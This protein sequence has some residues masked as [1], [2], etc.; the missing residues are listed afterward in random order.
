MAPLSESV[1]DLVKKK[2]RYA[3]F[4]LES[5]G[6]FDVLRQF[7]HLSQPRSFV[8]NNDLKQKS[9]VISIAKVAQTPFFI[10]SK[11]DT[12]KVNQFATSS[13][14]AIALVIM[15]G[16]GWVGLLTSIFI[17]R[18]L[19]PLNHLTQVAEA[20]S[21]G[22]YSKSIEIDGDNEISKL[23]QAFKKMLTKLIK[24]KTDVDRQVKRRTA[25]LEKLNRMMVGR[26]LKMIELKRQIKRLKQ[27]KSK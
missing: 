15:F 5:M 6:Y 3:D 20:I 1:A 25:Q 4:N 26:E 22:D 17:N 18:L 21:L 23:A 7:D 9:E 27:K 8:F 14:L 16:A 24:A 19:K 11:T 12:S 2:K 13:A 10:L